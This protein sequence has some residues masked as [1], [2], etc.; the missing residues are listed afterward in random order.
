MAVLENGEHCHQQAKNAEKC[1]EEI[2][3][4]ASD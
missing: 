4:M 3:Y 1:V 2:K